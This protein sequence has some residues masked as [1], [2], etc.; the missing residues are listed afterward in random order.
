MA[1]KG[2]SFSVTAAMRFN[3]PTMTS[4]PMITSTMPVTVAGMEK[5]EVMLAAMELTWLM[6]PIPKEAS[7]QKAENSTASTA[8]ICLQPL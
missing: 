3:P 7:R 8:P 4:A 6:L 1:I 2:T 5:A